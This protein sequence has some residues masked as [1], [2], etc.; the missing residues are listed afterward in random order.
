MQRKLSQWATD[1]PTKQF[2]DLYSLLCNETWLRVAHHSVNANQGRETAGIDGETM[3]HFNGNLEGNLEELRKQLKAKVF[4]PRPVQ[5]V[6]IP[7]PNGKKRPLG[8]PGLRDRIVQEALRMALEPIWEA[9]FSTHSYGFRPNRSTYDAI[10]YI[11]N[12]LTGNGQAFQW[13]IEGDIASYFDTIP[14]RRLIKAIKKRVADRNIRELL[15]KFLRAGVMYHGV[16]QDTP[17]GT[18][19]GGVISPLLANIYLHKLDRYMESTYL[20]ISHYDRVKRRKQGRGNY[21]Y[22]RYADDFVVLCNGTKAEALIIKEELKELLNTI[23]LT[24]SEEKTKVTHITEGFEFLGYKVIRGMGNSGKMVPKVHIPQKAIKRFQHKT[25]EILSASTTSESLNAKILAQN[26]LTRGWC[27]YYRATSSPTTTFTEL[28]HEMWWLMAHWLGRKYKTS[29]RQVAKRFGKDSTFKTKRATLLMPETYKAKKLLR[30]KWYNPYTAKA[31][32]IREKFLWYESIWSGEEGDRQGGS[33]LREEMILL[34]GTIC[35]I[36]GPDC[37]SQGKPLHPSEVEMDHIKLRAKFKDPTE[38]DR[39]GN[40]Q[41]VCT[42]C[43]RAKTKTDLKVL[44]R[45]R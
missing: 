11:G 22:V 40:L 45:M 13:I 18:P 26:A 27:Q 36:Q 32:I 19:Q 15:W 37:I 9:D 14:H 2:V 25:R 35:A 5:R 29:I 23:G 43:H 3:S 7:K 28:G 33:D 10:A 20:N 31:A 39:M 4:E 38:A 34:K 41:P 30:K 1:D 16:H 44:S 12:S 8:I 6:Y 21:L 24:L 17:M 42:P